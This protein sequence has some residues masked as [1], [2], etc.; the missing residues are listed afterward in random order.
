[1]GIGSVS[2]TVD[3]RSKWHRGLRRISN[4]I[5]EQ[6]TD[7]QI[8]NEMVAQVFADLAQAAFAL[9]RAHRFCYGVSAYRLPPTPRI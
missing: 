1:M 5:A 9:P 2:T 3:N 4:S 8:S 7:K 6:G